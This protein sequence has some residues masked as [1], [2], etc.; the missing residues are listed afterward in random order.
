MIDVNTRE[1][2]MFKNIDE[3]QKLGRGNMEV[4][5]KSFAVMS[6][7]FQAIAAEIANYSKSSL[8]D[9][10]AAMEKL[11]AAKTMQTA[12]EVQSEYVK[13]AYEAFI[14]QGSRIGELYARLAKETCKPFEL[15]ID[16][17]TST[18]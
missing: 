15:I 3:V 4:A 8:E 7:G 1:M 9:H 18:T 5:M 10:T 11:M 6:K 13:T 14:A 12:F 17:K 16:R 2:T